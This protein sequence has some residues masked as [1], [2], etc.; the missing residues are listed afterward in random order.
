VTK[1]YQL[2]DTLACEILQT[3]FD[4]PDIRV[5]IYCQI[6]KQLI[7]N[8]NQTSVE[9]GWKLLSL[10]MQVFSPGPSFENYVLIFIKKNAPSAVKTTLYQMCHRISFGGGER[11]PHSAAEVSHL[12]SS[13]DINRQ[14]TRGK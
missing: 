4:V 11:V 12:L 7:R 9:Y 3:G 13:A 2:P 5:E 14:S 1:K 10:C 8:P 6:M